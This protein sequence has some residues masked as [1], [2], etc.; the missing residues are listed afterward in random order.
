M[1]PRLSPEDME[2]LLI[3]PFLPPSRLAPSPELGPGRE[4]NDMKEEKGTKGEEGRRCD[5]VREDDDL[6]L[7]ATMLDLPLD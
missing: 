5:A 3:P 1:L 2:V 7:L 4:D 6:M